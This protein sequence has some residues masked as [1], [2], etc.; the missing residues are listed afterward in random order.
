MSRSSKCKQA[1]S[2]KSTTFECF[3]GVRSYYVQLN[4]DA[5][6]VVDRALI[7]QWGNFN[8]WLP[9]HNY[10]LE[11]YLSWYFQ[12]YPVC[13]MQRLLFRKNALSVLVVSN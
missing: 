8:K 3:L 9:M 13:T 7:V 1:S 2:L 12:M 5:L 11:Q 10:Y 6:F 4:P